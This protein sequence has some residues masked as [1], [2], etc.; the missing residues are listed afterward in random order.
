[1]ITLPQHAWEH[2]KEQRKLAESPAEETVARDFIAWAV[3]HYS[4]K[5]FHCDLHIW[6]LA[7]RSACVS[8]KNVKRMER[9]RKNFLCDA[10]RIDE[11]EDYDKMLENILKGATQSSQADMKEFITKLS[12]TRIPSE[13]SDESTR[14]LACE[15]I[16]AIHNQ[17]VG[18]TMA[19]RRTDR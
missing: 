7:N 4:A 11:V 14:K 15:Y 17:M 18:S 13:H 9:L 10:L 12:S 19:N 16:D 1:M 6:H 3:K 8:A 5:E 2:A